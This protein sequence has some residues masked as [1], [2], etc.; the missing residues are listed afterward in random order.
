MFTMDIRNIDIVYLHGPHRPERR[1]HMEKMFDK[2]ELKGS[3]FEGVCDKGKMSAVYGMISLMEDRLKGEFK[4][5]IFMEDDVSVTPWFRHVI[6]V[7]DGT[8][9]VYLGI[10]LYSLH[11]YIDRAIP[12]IQADKVADFPDLLR[13]H[14]MLSTHAVLFNTRRWTE[15]CLECYRRTLR[16]NSASQS[17]DFDFYPARSMPNFRV[18]ALKQPL[19]Y[20]DA[21]VGGQQDPT[22]IQLKV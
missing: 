16:E 10:S 14:N 19:F 20:Q 6:D 18:Y 11:P 4:P 7:P 12:V 9:A 2:N 15:N 8:D 3:C 5:F 13:L 22:L 1:E 17:P 21:A